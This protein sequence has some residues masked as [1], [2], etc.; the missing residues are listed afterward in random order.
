MYFTHFDLKSL[1]IVQL[2]SQYN[3]ITTLKGLSGLGSRYTT[4]LGMNI[5]VAEKSVWDE[6]TTVCFLKELLFLIQ[7]LISL[8]RNIPGLPHLLTR[9]FH[10]T[11][12]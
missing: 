11:I 1:T 12:L 6:Y 9:A 7:G 3:I 4:E 8:D 2:R 10:Y 5:G